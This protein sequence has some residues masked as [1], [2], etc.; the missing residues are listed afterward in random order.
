MSGKK[1]KMAK[2]KFAV[3]TQNN[4]DG[5]AG[6]RFFAT[7]ELAEEV[8]EKDDE[9]FCDDICTME[10]KIDLTTGKIVSGVAT[11]VEDDGLGDDGN[12]IG[13]SGE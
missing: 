7:E 4:G 11:E 9:R 10:L 8:A 5:S 13:L 12:V 1:R 3:W 6:P 2:V